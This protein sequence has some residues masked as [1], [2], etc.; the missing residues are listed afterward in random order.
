M[1]PYIQTRLVIY[2]TETVPIPILDKNEQ[3]QLYTQLKMKK[4]IYSIKSGDLH[5]LT[6]TRTKHM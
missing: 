4:N 1:Q 3:A 5:Y 2:Q 6:Y